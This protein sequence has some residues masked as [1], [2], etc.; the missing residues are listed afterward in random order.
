M[1]KPHLIIVCV[2]FA[3]ICSAQTVKNS[4]LKQHL[5][6]KIKKIES[7]SYT[8]DANTGIVDTLAPAGKIIDLYD[9][10][11]NEVEETYMGKEDKK[12]SKW[13]WKYNEKNEKI[14]EDYFADTGVL[15]AT[16]LF[17]YDAKGNLAESDHDFIPDKT[18]SNKTLYKYDEKD[19][20][21]EEDTYAGDGLLKYKNIYKYDSKGNRIEMDYW[22]AKED[23][24]RVKWTFDYNDAGLRVK[25]DRYSSRGEL[26]IENLLTYENLDKLGNWLLETR[27]SQGKTK[28]FARISS[29]SVTK[30]KIYYY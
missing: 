7:S 27:R 1:K 16:T 28:E 14:E 29:Y 4:L 17:K 15:Q 18:N 23:T 5:K 10:N 19:N 11:G 30:Q 12:V 24:I 13:L 2:L 21:V 9:E 26:Q 20:N 22:H 8:G 6:G 25:E 3:Q